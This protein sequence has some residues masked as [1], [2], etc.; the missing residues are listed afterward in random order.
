MN[1]VWGPRPLNLAVVEVLQRKGPLA[2]D[3]L[4]DEVKESY[5]EI[6][7]RELNTVL[8]KLELNGILRVTR[9]MKGKRRVELVEHRHA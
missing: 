9:L 4:L 6:S 3:D 1:K 5:G 2:D 8:L 7:F